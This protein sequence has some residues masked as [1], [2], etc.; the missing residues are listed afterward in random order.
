MRDAPLAKRLTARQAV[1]L[2]DGS[3]SLSDLSPL[4]GVAAL[5]V[6]LDGARRIGRDTITRMR[7]RLR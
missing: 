6:D 5:V 7:A 2:L 3:T 4:T 1:D